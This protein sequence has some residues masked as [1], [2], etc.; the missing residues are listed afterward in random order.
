MF[1]SIVIPV[2]EGVFASRDKNDLMIGRRRVSIFDLHDDE[3]AH[4]NKNTR[5]LEISQYVRSKLAE[6]KEARL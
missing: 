1:M 6:L 2:V 4:F 3:L 5:E